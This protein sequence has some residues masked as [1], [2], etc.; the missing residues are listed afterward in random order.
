MTRSQRLP[1]TV[2]QVDQG[3]W[4]DVVIDADT[5]RVLEIVTHIQPSSL[6]AFAPTVFNGLARLKDLEWL[7]LGQTNMESA[8]H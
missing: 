6:D 2:Y 8:C 4:M 7:G 1:V 3:S 5:F